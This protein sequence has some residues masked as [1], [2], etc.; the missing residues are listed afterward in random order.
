MERMKTQNPKK[1]IRIT[2]NQPL[3]KKMKKIVSKENIKK[4][5]K[6]KLKMERPG[7]ICLTENEKEMKI[8]KELKKEKKALKLIPMELAIL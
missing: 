8:E 7:E 5:K 1:R 4:K 3:R 6:K 2:P